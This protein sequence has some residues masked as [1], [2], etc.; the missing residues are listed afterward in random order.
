[1]GGVRLH[2]LGGSMKSLRLQ[3]A[4][5]LIAVGM[6]VSIIIGTTMYSQYNSYIDSSLENI[7]VSSS[8]AI[9]ELY[10][11]SDNEYWER[12]G[13][14][15]SEIYLSL[16]KNMKVIKESYNLAYIYS[17]K[18]ASGGKFIFILDTANLYDDEDDWTFL[19]EYE[20]APVEVGQAY[21]SRKGVLAEPYTD[22][23][24]SFLSYY[25]P[26]KNS[27]GK[28]TGVLGVDYDIT[29]VNSLK[30]RALVIFLVILLGSIVFIVFAGIYF[31]RLIINPILNAVSITDRIA[32]GEL[33]VD[34]EK[35]YLE[36]KDETG[37]LIRSLF[38]MTK[39]LRSI[40]ASVLKATIQMEHA[41]EL[42]ANDNAALSERT[43]EQ[44]AALEETFAAIEEMNGSVKSNAD[45]TQTADS[46]SREAANQ[47]SAGSSSVTSVIG[48]M[49]EINDSSNRIADIIEV[50]NNIAFQTNLLALNAS[51]EAARAG[52]QGKGFAVVAVE[53]RKLAKR[54]DKAAKEISDIIKSSNIKVDEGV[55]VANRAGEV[56]NEINQSVKKVT[57]I[58]GEISA[59][60]QEQLTSVD[61]IDKTLASLDKNTQMNSSMVEKAAEATGRLSRQA[62]ELSKMME[63]FKIDDTEDENDSYLEYYN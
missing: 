57:N 38:N 24:G 15:R 53:V 29:Y 17:M 46:L 1:M 42:I 21:N 23:W 52:E 26:I 41:S 43:E 56:L 59:A 28:V 7:L 10:D 5:L 16:L 14:K 4:L 51:I 58:V 12:E 20:G 60:S 2:I 34:I 62:K 32:R 48:S 22:Q 50:I 31:S 49:N 13:T 8:N 3:I 27:S 35:Q 11:I 45:N 55:G 19:L 63:F 6:V 39:N 33:E 9:K 36:R 44:A 61:E 18:P 47:T 37:S 30:N 40:V 25:S 54:S